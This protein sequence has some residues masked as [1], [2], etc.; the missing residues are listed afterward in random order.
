MHSEVYVFWTGDGVVV[1]RITRHAA[2]SYKRI[3]NHRL[4]LWDN[5]PVNDGSPT[6]HLGPVSGRDPDLPSVI[7]GYPSNPLA[8]QNEINR[9]PL[10][11][12]R[13]LCL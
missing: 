5:Y 1:P 2:E 12:L 3:V 10:A 11:D 9:L 8:S 13:R 7:D 4:F 6:L